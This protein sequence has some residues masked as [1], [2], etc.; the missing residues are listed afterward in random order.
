MHRRRFDQLFPQL[1]TDHACN[2]PS[3]PARQ[4]YADLANML[5]LGG[6]TTDEKVIKLIEAVED[7]KKKVDIPPTIKEIFNDPKTDADFLSH[8]DAW[9]LV[10][11]WL[12]RGPR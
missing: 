9:V 10:P 5:G 7:L 8:V 2:P 11:R 12:G 3:R 1:V 6:N 4:D